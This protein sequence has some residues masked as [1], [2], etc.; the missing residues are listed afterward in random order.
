MSGKG[1]WKLSRERG[2]VPRLP[3]KYMIQLYW[4]VPLNPNLPSGPVHPYQLDESISNFMGFLVY[5]I[6]LILFEKIFL[7]ANGEEHDQ[8]TRTAA[9][10]LGLNCLPISKNGT[11]GLYGPRQ[12]NLVL[13]AYAS[14][15][16]SGEPAHPRSLARTSAARSYKLWVK[17]KLQTESQI[18][19]TSE[20]LGMR[21]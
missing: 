15:E 9:S 3:T 21:S 18:P 20:W 13:I 12:A 1:V 19:G 11:L 5:F 6:I 16:G 2:K 7:K 10:D 17:R 4:S 8:T 14:S